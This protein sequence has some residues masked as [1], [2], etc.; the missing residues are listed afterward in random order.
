MSLELE[1]VSDCKSDD[2]DEEKGI[3]HCNE[4][5]KQNGNSG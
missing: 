5:N 4:L 3:S 1:A 2:S